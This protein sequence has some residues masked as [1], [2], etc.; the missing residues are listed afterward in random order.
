MR[1]LRSVLLMLCV[2]SYAHGLTLDGLEIKGWGQGDTNAASAFYPVRDASPRWINAETNY[3]FARDIWAHDLHQAWAERARAA[4]VSFDTNLIQ[5]VRWE[6]QHLTDLK[7]FAETV[8]VAYLDL[9]YRTNGTY[10]VWYSQFTGYT[11]NISLF[12]YQMTVTNPPNWTVTAALEWANMPTN[13]FE[14]TP[15]RFLG[16]T[17]ISYTNEHTLSGGGTNVWTTLDYGW[18]GLVRLLAV[19]EDALISVDRLADFSTLVISN[20]FC[21]V[22]NVFVNTSLYAPDEGCNLTESDFDPFDV[23]IFIKSGIGQSGLA[24]DFEAYLSTLL[25]PANPTNNWTGWRGSNEAST[26]GLFYAVPSTF[27]QPYIDSD[28]EQTYLFYDAI[29]YFESREIPRQLGTD[30]I[31]TNV[32]D[33][34]F[35]LRYTATSNDVPSG[36]VHG[37]PETDNNGEVYLVGP[38][39]AGG[40]LL[41]TCQESWETSDDPDVFQPPLVPCADETWSSQDNYF[42]TVRGYGYRQYAP[43]LIV[44]PGWVYKPED[45]L[46]Y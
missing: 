20:D 34:P 30:T 16:A 39:L 42:A 26:N 14:Y 6:H 1:V 43:R 22:T 36:F 11:N 13:F 3:L 28:M 35:A 17:S 18:D 7:A 33:A 46:I 38:P 12:D 37:F 4:L 2:V 19:C 25:D 44:R 24:Y 32:V 10:N 40:G 41:G 5:G 9:N 8:V 21:A 31:S 27:A 29:A 45:V 15:A 23:D